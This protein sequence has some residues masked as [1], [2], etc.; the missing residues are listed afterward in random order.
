MKELA[1]ALIFFAVTLVLFS[2][3]GSR[4]SGE[5]LTH[6]IEAE[7]REIAHVR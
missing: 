5:P 1:A 6:R 4:Y 3:M 7:L 2:R